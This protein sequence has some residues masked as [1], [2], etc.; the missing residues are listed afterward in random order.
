MKLYSYWRSTAS[1]RVRIALALKGLSYEYMPVHLVQD[2]GQQHADSYR[3]LNPEGLVPFLVDNDVKISQS[4]AIINYLEKEYPEISLCSGSAKLD[5]EIESFAMSIA[6]DIHPLN[7]LR[8]IKYLTKEMHITTE[9]SA[10]WYEHWIATGFSALEKRLEKSE[11]EFALTDFVS[12]ADIYL[13]AQVYNAH[14]FKCDM[15]PYPQINN[16]NAKCLDLPAFQ[17]ALPENQPDAE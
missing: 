4:Y 13:V 1:Y 14:R 7:N 9:Q 15:T 8:V 10:A 6:C 12:V 11:T 16:L 5:A 17:A 2:G 3:E